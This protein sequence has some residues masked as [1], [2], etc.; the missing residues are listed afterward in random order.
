MG[1]WTFVS[2]VG[3]AFL[4]WFVLVF[5]FTPR[6]DYHLTGPLA[7]EAQLLRVLQEECQARLHAGNC[8]TVLTNGTQFYP[9]MLA[10]IREAHHSINVE[11]YIFEPGEIVD[12][13]VAA[14]AERAKAG[15]EVRIVLDAIG[16]SH[17]RLSAA[18]SRL[19]EAGCRLRYYQRLT[20]YRLHRAN[21]R[22]HRELL[23]V[24]GRVA[25]VGGAGVA[26]WWYRPS[27][28]EEPAWRDTMVRVDGPVV[29]SLQGVFAENWLECEG[30]I[31]TS[32]ACWPPL[33]SAGPVDAML[34]R[35]SPA[36]RA[37]ASRVG[38]QLLMSWAR[39]T[40]D[41]S[42]PYFL[43]DFTLRRFL[44]ETAAR[45]VRIR[46]IVPGP[47]TDQRFV[48]LASRRLYGPLLEAGLRIYEYQPGMTHAKALMIDGRLAVVGTTNIDNRSFEHNDEVNVAFR[49]PEV[50]TRLTGDFEADLGQSEEMTY[51]R[52][53]QRPLLEKAL[54]PLTW[55]LER[56]Q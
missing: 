33:G 26:D 52:W 11:A 20:W 37:T 28:P 3:L 38:F 35:S 21:N 55:L 2:L 10:A 47:R 9:A 15:V 5:L 49:D 29:A 30:E 6:I 39:D 42:T 40:I 34:I 50:V 24:D 7:D 19:T 13:V 31:L 41:I 56:Q 48:R 43:P 36:D 22:T 17:M 23:I 44:M 16:S 8:A 18:S 53:R 4:V 1:P 32:P 27:S 51:E 54:K 12:Q 25:F 45:G 46:V 14:L